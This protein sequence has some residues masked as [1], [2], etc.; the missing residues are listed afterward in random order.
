MID[1]TISGG[2]GGAA[3]G[4][5]TGFAVGGPWGAAIGGAIGGIAGILSGGGEDDAK[6]AAQ[7][8]ARMIE[9]QAREEER[10]KILYMNAQV[11]LTK[12]TSFANNLQ[13]SGSAKKYRNTMEAEYRRQLEYDRI[14][15]NKTVEYTLEGGQN[16]A[17]AISRAGVGSMFESFGQLGAAYVG[18]AFDKPPPPPGGGSSSNSAATNRAGGFYGTGL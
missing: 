12:A 2:I 15:T 14:V 17:D 18:G 5:S 9:M 11:G 4:A 6:K 7:N 10:K 16:A 3:S 1:S 13:D 8:Q